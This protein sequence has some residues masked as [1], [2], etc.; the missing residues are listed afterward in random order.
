MNKQKIGQI[1]VETVIYTL[2]GLALIGLVLAIVTP[3]INELNDRSIIE[4]TIESLGIFDSKIKEVLAAPGN[5]RIVEFKI[6]RG[7]LYFNGTGD[8]I[9]YV[10]DDSRALY[11]EPNAVIQ[12][13]KLKVLTI[14]GN[15]RHSVSLWVNYTQNIT[16]DGLD[17]ANYVKFSP[18]SVPYKFSIENKGFQNAGKVWIDL[19]EVS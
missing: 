18:A 10:I 19:R 1:W 12:F 5:V 3:K 2:I 9:R 6:K 14:E 7:D 15:K 4:Q 11:S 16:F 13:G 17:N 8:E